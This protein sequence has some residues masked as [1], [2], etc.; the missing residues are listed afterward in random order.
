MSSGKRLFTIIVFIGCLF[1][2]TILSL[3]IFIIPPDAGPEYY[4]DKA[5]YYGLNIIFWFSAPYLL[6]IVIRKIIW[7]SE[8]K[9]I[10][11]TKTIGMIEDISIVLIYFI[12]IG[13]LAA[14][15]FSLKISIEL[16]LL[17]FA[18]MA[19]TI[20]LRPS[21]LKLA[22]TGFIQSARPFKT[23]DWISLRNQN[24]ESILAGKIINFDGKS[25]Q[26]KS[27]NNT[28][29]IL[30]NSLLTNFVIENYKAIEKEVLFS[31][32]ISLGPDISVEQAKRI[33]TAAAKHSLLNISE[34]NS[35]YAEVIVTDV[36]K[37]S[38]EYKIIFGFTPWE[39]LSPEQMK[40]TILCNAIDHLDK[41]GIK[42]HKDETHNIIEHVAL[43]ENLEK[44]EM[45]ELISSAGTI[46]YT[47][48]E[49]IIKQGEDGSSM[50]ILQEGLLNVFI[51]TNDNEKLKVSVIAPGEFFGEMSLFTGEKRS[52]TVAAE[53]DSVVMEIG[54]E[55]IK[56]ILDKQPDLVNGFGEIITE[57]QTGNLKK[58]DDYLSRKESF[59][60]KLVA[61]IKSFF[62]L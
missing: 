54:K 23:G 19:V 18:L 44:N 56:K 24:A 20:Y 34:S 26:L 5:Y 13:I 32:Q 39:P 61:K 37:D 4:L 52:A 15:L 35:N 17:Y 55:A 6:G 9:N 53:T 41:A 27:E 62:D 45:K 50:F 40:D 10:M 7:R 58:M 59:I 25:I 11:G 36:S 57:R 42:F 12:S 28:L 3:N 16:S 33:L 60:H 21:F 38:I 22:K 46:L 8:F 31:L 49:T 51:S 14:K 47:A 43:F 30:P 1:S 2:L 48:G 29:L